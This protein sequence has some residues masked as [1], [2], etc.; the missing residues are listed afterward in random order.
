[1]RKPIVLIFFMVY[2]LTVFNTVLLGAEGQAVMIIDI[3]ASSLS[4]GEYFGKA[5]DFDGEFLKVKVIIKDH[6]IEKIK[7]I[8]SKEDAYVYM[9]SGLIP[10]IVELQSVEID[11]VSGATVSSKALLAAIKDALSTQVVRSSPPRF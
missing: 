3:D 11:T 10:L 4:D 6:E 1:M 2:G 8:E 7:I 9:A 5:D